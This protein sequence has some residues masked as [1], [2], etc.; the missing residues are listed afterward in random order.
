MIRINDIIDKVA[1]NNPDAD[2]S[3]I[4]RAYVFSAR[5]HDGQVRLSGEPYLSHPL[6]VAGILADMKLD[7]ISVAAGLLHDVVEDTHATEGEIREMFGREVQHIVSGV[8][9]LSKLPFNSSQA[10]E[11]ES[12]RKM[13]LAMADDIRVIMIKLADRLHNMRTLQYHRSEK[14]RCKIAQET[15]DIYAAI[16]AR[17]GIYWIKNELENISF[18]YLLPSAYETIAN[19]VAKER[20]EREEYIGTVKSYIK[21]KMDDNR[22]PCAVEG[23]FKNFYSIHQKMTKQDLSF[24]EIYDLIA[25]R[26]I[27]DTIPQCYEALGVVHSLWKPIA[28]K[29]KDY[30]GMPKPNMYQSLHTTV[31]GPLG[32]RIE[33]QIRTYEM[34][35]VA[36]SGIAAHWSYKEGQKPDETMTKTFA[37]VRNLVENHA[38]V[39]D[40]NEFLENVRIDLFPDEVYVFTPQGE[41]KS[42]PKGATPVDFAYLIHTEVGNQCTGAK[43]NGRMVPLKY[44]LQTGE[45]VEIITTKGHQPS[46]DWLNFVQTVKARSK[47]RQWIKTQ[48]KERSLTLGREMCEKAFRKYRLN[49]NMLLKSD[50]M[51]KVVEHFGFKTTDDLIASV[52]YGK[53]TP[54][55]V[56]RRFV[57]RTDEDAADSLIDKLIGRVRKKRKPKGGVLVKGL[58]D[59]LIR[60]GKCCQPVPG[61]PIVGYITR[62]HGVTVHRSSCINVFNTSPER[63]I[64]VEWNTEKSESYPVRIVV[65]SHDRMGLLADIASVIAKYGANIVKANT[66]TSE[67]KTVDS[68]FTLAVDGTDQLDRVVTALR[69]IKHVLAVKRLG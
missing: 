67:N 48:E 21:A 66:Q 54:L 47:I 15:L 6:E 37:W 29:F 56:V 13:L 35:R 41:I 52:G 49:F 27:L 9:K 64:E 33:I 63:H 14:K 23:R 17:L 44:E 4:E 65:H 12:I 16:A 62:G 22:L 36:N 57:P 53:I 20:A 39:G 10:R 26:I 55:Q 30:I 51:A 2:L 7:V 11:A 43:V 34:D 5:V 38:N 68:Y 19:R 42:L 32:D 18:R 45:I 31:I 24:E 50:E 28:K 58:E 25:F 46:K 8:T 59:M 60:F 69:K 40:P 1:E 3:I 61:D